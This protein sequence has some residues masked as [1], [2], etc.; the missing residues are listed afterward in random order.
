MAFFSFLEGYKRLAMIGLGISIVETDA[1]KE[2]GK[3]IQT[4]A[5]RVL[6]TYD[7]GWPPL[8]PET[9]ERKRTGDSPLLETGELRDSIEYEVV[10]KLLYIGSNN[11][12]A[13]WH[14]YGT[15]RGIP[16][17]P[18]LS[19]AANAKHEEVTHLIGK[20]IA[21]SIVESFLAGRLIST[22]QT[23]TVIQQQSVFGGIGS[24]L[25]RIF[26]RR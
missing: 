25:G 4:E 20:H 16:P 8:Q 9:I 12:K 19:G 10:G 11:P 21:D 17:R 24:R 22:L 5:K 13:E 2:A 18:F 3:V 7:Y 1:L 6:G 15:S 26:R 23:A 14:E